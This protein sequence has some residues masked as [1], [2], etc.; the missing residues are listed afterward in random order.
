MQS[1]EYKEVGD[2][3]AF[4]DRGVATLRAAVTA[5]SDPAYAYE[6]LVIKPD[7]VMT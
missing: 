3:E 2:Q 5:A 1:R 6:G 7:P 4:F